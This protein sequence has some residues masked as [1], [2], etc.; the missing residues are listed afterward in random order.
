MFEE[1]VAGVE[2]SVGIPVGALGEN[3]FNGGRCGF[4]PTGASNTWLNRDIG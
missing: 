3:K 2:T 4:G 1:D